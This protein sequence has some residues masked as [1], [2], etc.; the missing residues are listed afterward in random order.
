MLNLR[1]GNNDTVADQWK[2]GGKD[3][4]NKKQRPWAKRGEGAAKGGQRA[5]RSAANGE[6]KKPLG[7]VRA[8]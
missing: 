1:N 4:N 3:L 8:T 5:G 6:G 7:K 2:E